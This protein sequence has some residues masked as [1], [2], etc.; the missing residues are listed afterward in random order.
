MAY[1]FFVS[2]EFFA[3]MGI[4]VLEGRD[5]TADDRG[6]PVVIID[7]LLAERHF[8]GRNAVGDTLTF[9]ASTQGGGGST[10]VGVVESTR[11]NGPEDRSGQPFVFIPLSRAANYT[12]LLRTD[13]PADDVLR[14]V[15]EKLRAVDPSVPMY[16]SGSLQ[17][18]VDLQLK[19]R[20]GIMLLLVAFAGL[21]LLLSAVGIY[22][23]VAYDVTQR[24]REIGIR[25]ALGATRGQIVGLI[26]RQSLWKVG[27]G[28]IAGLA[29]SLYLVRFLGELL[30][31]VPPVDPMAYAIV[32]LALIS[33][34]F[35]ASYL[36]ARR[37]ARINPVEALRVA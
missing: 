22:G 23:V 15:R 4:R 5:F 12:L 33:V 10:I 32:C 11:I 37:S 18:R 8:P 3:A 24:T 2:P 13:R 17:S 7:R 36:P 20:R 16:M 9:G 1:T 29:L 21:A 30:Y 26:I 28:L 31:D 35:L 34:A 14:S 19:D 6:K 27:I 25:G